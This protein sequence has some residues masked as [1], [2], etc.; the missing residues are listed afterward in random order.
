MFVQG[1]AL[2]QSTEAVNTVLK[3]RNLSF[4]PSALEV[5]N[6]VGTVVRDHAY[7]EGLSDMVVPMLDAY[8]TWVEQYDI[9]VMS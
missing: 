8:V 2:R 4:I 6:V 9:P 5:A 3:K 1:E 7:K